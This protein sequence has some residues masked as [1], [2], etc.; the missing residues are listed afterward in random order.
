MIACPWMAVAEKPT[1]P[2]TPNSPGTI[3][4]ELVLLSAHY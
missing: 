2:H 1:S 3:V 4:K